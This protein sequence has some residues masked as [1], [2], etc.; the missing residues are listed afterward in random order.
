[1]LTA[2]IAGNVV[3]TSLRFLVV[4]LA[5]LGTSVLVARALGPE[6]FG[7]YR[8]VM[9]LVWGLEVAAVL[10][11]PNAVTKFTAELS[12]LDERGRDGHVLT[13][14]GRQA[15]LMYLVVTVPV[16]FL[17]DHIAR[18]FHDAAI[19]P[20]L[21]LGALA[22]LPGVYGGL[23]AGAMRGRQRFR[24]LAALG[25]WQS[26]LAVVGT[27][28][29]VALGYGLPG[30]FILF[31]ALN[32]INLALS[33]YAMREQWVGGRRGPSP[34]TSGGSPCLESLAGRMWWYGA[35]MGLIA[36]LGAVI[37]ERSEIFFLGR[38]ATAAQVGFYSLAYTLALHLRRLL[39]TSFGEVLFPVFARWQGLGDEPRIAA[40]FVQTT[41]YLTMVACPLVIGGALFAA[42]AI[43][44]L[45]GA[46]Y[47]PA[48]PVLAILLLAAGAVAV[49]QPA[50]AILVNK[51]QYPVPDRLVRGA[52]RRQR[53]ARRPPD[54]CLGRARR[55][56]R[57]HDD[58]AGGR[59][60]A[61]PGRGPA[62]RHPFPAE[63]ARPRRH[64]RRP[65][66]V[67]RV[68]PQ[69]ERRRDRTGP[70][71][72]RLRPQLSNRAPA[73]RGARGRGRRAAPGDCRR[74]PRSPAPPRHRRHR[75]PPVAPRL[76]ASLMARVKRSS[77]GW[78]RR[79]RGGCGVGCVVTTRLAASEWAPSDC[80]AHGDRR[81]ETGP[82][83][84]TPHPPRP[85]RPPLRELCLG[86]SLLHPMFG[87]VNRRGRG[88]W[89]VPR[90]L[91]KPVSRR[92]S[93]YALQ[94]DGAQPRT[95]PAA[96]ALVV[97]GAPLG[98]PQPPCP[99]GVRD[100]LQ[101]TR[102]RA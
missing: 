27:G 62:A 15:T 2:S 50:A 33:V 45:F 75:R 94:P 83:H 46:A 92:P 59:P 35:V 10:A 70:R 40:A 44:L 49:A 95:V 61:A 85:R 24:E 20:L 47:L 9:G 91:L 84:P 66:R 77:L 31:F 17:A 100:E 1:M 64:R 57:E 69:R 68:G 8:L 21:I 89:G 60:R 26:V 76:M 101:D 32:L 98:T 30:L 63:H 12:G 52:R 28:L 72:D 4:L 54:S 80:G 90:G 37:W 3:V 13:F 93:P 53:G 22:V 88:G 19:A 74:V 34:A 102:C 79:G 6:E 78:R 73:G 36:L 96:A 81:R 55:C 41:R 18:F 99:V 5:G 48:A 29:V 86:Q 43:R 97:S 67:A 14:F 42:P 11:F 16:L 23:L 39:T 58:P 82:T 65:R 51:E 7:T 56:R 71:A 38:W 87:T 25:L